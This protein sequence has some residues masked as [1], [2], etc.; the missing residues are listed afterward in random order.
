MLSIAIDVADSHV[1]PADQW[2]E[3]LRIKEKTVFPGAPDIPEN[4]L[5]SLV[6]D[7]FDVS[8]AG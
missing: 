7:G 5:S 3:T 4:V 8:K 2:M 6:E 1:R